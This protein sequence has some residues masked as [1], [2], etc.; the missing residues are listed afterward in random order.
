MTLIEEA[1]KEVIIVSPYVQIKNWDKMRKCL[2]RAIKRNINIVFITRKNPCPDLTQ[3]EN[4]GINPILIDDLHAKFYINDRY[5]IV[6][7][8]NILQY[9][10]NHSIDIGYKTD[11]VRERRELV[12]FVNKYLIDLRNQDRSSVSFLQNKETQINK[13]LNDWQVGSLYRTLVENFR[14]V[15]FKRTATYIFSSDLMPF[16]DVMIDSDLTIK[17][18]KRRTDSHLILEKLNEILLNNFNHHKIVIED[19]HK[20][21]HYIYITSKNQLEFDRVINDYI[22]LTQ[23]ILSSDIHKLLRPQIKFPIW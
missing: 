18:D 3:L 21:Y 15:N 10:D 4:L 11:V 19:T 5:A 12:D 7:S 22:E 14:K 23:F 6:T 17:F 16:G 1:E 8:Q 9:S 20:R 2:E 13:T